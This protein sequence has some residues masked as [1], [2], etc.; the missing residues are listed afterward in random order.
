MWAVG[1][2]QS[3]GRRVLK[4]LWKFVLL[5]QLYFTSIGAS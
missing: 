1:E 5:D 4:E 3:F 2:R